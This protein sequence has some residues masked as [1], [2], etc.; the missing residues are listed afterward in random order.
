MRAT[1]ILRRARASTI[2]DLGRAPRL[3]LNGFHFFNDDG[4]IPAVSEVVPVE[5]ARARFQGMRSFNDAPQRL[6]ATGILQGMRSA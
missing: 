1:H 6:G 3:A 5:E 4:V 2:N